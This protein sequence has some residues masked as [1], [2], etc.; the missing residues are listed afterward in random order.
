[1]NALHAQMALLVDEALRYAKRTGKGEA[2]VVWYLVGR[3]GM[4]IPIDYFDSEPVDEE[5]SV[6]C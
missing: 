6:G 5:E 1:M 2:M 4:D 3:L